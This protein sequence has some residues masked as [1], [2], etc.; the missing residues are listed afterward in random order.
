MEADT[1]ND[2]DTDKWYRNDYYV[3][4]VPTQY[5][6]E[7]AEKLNPPNQ[8]DERF[9]PREVQKGNTARAMFYFI[10]YMEIMMHPQ[11]FGIS[12]NNN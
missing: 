9:E 8:E 4:T 10:L 11:I 5:I 7:Y 6:D 3:E 12:K 2:N 1:D